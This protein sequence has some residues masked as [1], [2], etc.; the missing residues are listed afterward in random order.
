MQIILGA[1]ADEEL[2][3]ENESS[4]WLQGSI[5]ISREVGLR[6]I[7]KKNRYITPLA[8]R[9]DICEFF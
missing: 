2:K 1:S 6:E 7:M 9:Y 4:N 3:T 8:H 5:I